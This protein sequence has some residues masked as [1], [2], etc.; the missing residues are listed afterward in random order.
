MSRFLHAL[1][2]T[3]L[4]HYGQDLP[5]SL[6][7][8]CKQLSWWFNI[9]PGYRGG[10]ISDAVDSLQ[11]CRED[12]KYLPW[13]AKETVVRVTEMFR[14]RDEYFLTLS[15][16]VLLLVVLFLL[17]L[18]VILFVTNCCCRNNRAGP[19]VAREDDL[20]RPNGAVA[21]PPYE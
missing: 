20:D 10:L 15:V 12:Y 9:W 21:P 2:E 14:L 7:R 17:L 3:L 1:Y 8:V 16:E 13:N 19:R 11:I 18:V 4:N 6:N 5:Q